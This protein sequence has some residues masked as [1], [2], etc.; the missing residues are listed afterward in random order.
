MTVKKQCV[1]CKTV[2]EAD[3]YEGLKQYFYVKQD[4]LRNE[5]I[6][7]EKED[8]RKSMP[9]ESITIVKE[10]MYIKRTIGLVVFERR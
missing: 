4:W 2:Y 3:T 1:T 8:H 10:M 7:C 9:M 5:C 6:E